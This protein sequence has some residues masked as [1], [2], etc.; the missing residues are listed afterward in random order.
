MLDLVR[1]LET[2]AGSL[3]DAGIPYAICGGLAVTIHGA[4]R[5]TRDIDLLVREEDLE[6][7]VVQVR[8]HGWRFRAL[9]MVF[10][11]GKPQERRLTRVTRL[12]GKLVLMLDLITVTPFWEDV[13]DG[14]LRLHVGE[15]ELS[16]VSREGLAKMKRIAGRPQDLADLQNLGLET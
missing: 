6:A 15:R 11:A 8:D 3:D 13:F 5:S 7:F 10:D 14:R 1:E 2:V 4:V 16:V 9:P 12:E